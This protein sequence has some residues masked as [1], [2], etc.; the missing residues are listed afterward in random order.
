MRSRISVG[1]LVARRGIAGIVG[2]VTSLRYGKARV[3]WSEHTATWTA[4]SNLVCKG[5]GRGRRCVMHL[6]RLGVSERIRSGNTLPMPQL[7]PQEREEAH[8]RGQGP[9]SSPRRFIWDF[10]GA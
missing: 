7:R 9:L 6:E 3:F 8:G 4:I 5:D 10:S 2:R 1:S